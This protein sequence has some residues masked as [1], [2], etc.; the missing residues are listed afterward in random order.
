MF[1]RKIYLRKYEIGYFEFSKL[2][3]LGKR[4]NPNAFIE[5]GVFTNGLLVEEGNGYTINKENWF[6]YLDCL[7]NDISV[8]EEAGKI[9][10]VFEP[11]SKQLL[12]ITSLLQANISHLNPILDKQVIMIFGNHGCGKST[13]ANVLINSS[14]NIDYE[15]GRFNT[16]IPIMYQNMEMFQ[17]KHLSKVNEE[18]VDFAPID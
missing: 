16:C 13:L 5:D 9:D 4:G 1:G 15:E 12:T 6:D 18:L 14:K 8:V 2:H 17:I 7:N 10:K 11:I 3:G